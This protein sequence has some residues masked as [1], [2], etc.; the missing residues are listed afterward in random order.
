M[1]FLPKFTASG[2]FYIIFTKFAI[3]SAICCMILFVK[4]LTLL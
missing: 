2:V 1:A 3:N 4:K